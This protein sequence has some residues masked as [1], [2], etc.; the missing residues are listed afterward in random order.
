MTEIKKSKCCMCGKEHIRR[1]GDMYKCNYK[2][3]VRHFCGYNCYIQ[4]MKLKETKQHDK[5][6]EIFESLSVV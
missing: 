6:H 2:G 3:H 1:Y 4:F 5:I